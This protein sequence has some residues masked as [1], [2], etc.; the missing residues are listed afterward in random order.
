MARIT[1][2]HTEYNFDFKADA[3][4]I[5]LCDTEDPNTDIFIAKKFLEENSDVVPA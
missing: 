4:S 2:G 3:V 1:S 5:E